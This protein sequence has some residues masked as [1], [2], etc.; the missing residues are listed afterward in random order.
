MK[1]ET[2]AI[3]T[4]YKQYGHIEYGERCTQL[5]HSVQAGLIAKERGLDDELIAAAFLHDIGHLCPLEQ[6][7]EFET[8]GDYG[9]DAHDKWGEDYL[10]QMGFSERVTAVVRN[11]V[12]AKRYLCFV[13]AEYYSQLSDASKETMKFQGGVM[14]AAQARAFKADPFF[15]DSITIRRIDEAAKGLDFEVTSAHWDYLT[16]LIDR[17]LS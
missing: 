8:M 13:D 12:D 9:V 1:N 5:A 2:Q 10:R 17:I 15:E 7:A 11:H 16:A 14:D 6:E 4:L 3:V